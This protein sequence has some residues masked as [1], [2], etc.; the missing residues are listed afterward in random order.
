MKRREMDSEMTTQ[1]KDALH[2]KNEI[3]RWNAWKDR[4]SSKINYKVQQ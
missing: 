3:S 4:K 1:D 2:T